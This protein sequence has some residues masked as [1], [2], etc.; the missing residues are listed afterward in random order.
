MGRDVHAG[1][2]HLAAVDPPAVDAV[3][4]LA[5]RAGFHVGRVA[6]MVGFG[7]AEGGAAAPLAP[8]EDEFLPLLVA[9]RGLFEHRAEGEM[10]DCA[11]LV[12]KNIV[13]IGRASCRTR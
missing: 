11:M 2:P 4:G 10:A 1:D 12:F 13:W 5:H 6:A 9:R 7:Q 3:A 8:A